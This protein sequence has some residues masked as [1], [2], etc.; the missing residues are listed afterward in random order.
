MQKIKLILPFIL[1]VLVK[2]VLLAQTIDP[3]F[4]LSKEYQVIDGFGAAVPDWLY[5]YNLES[6]V[7]DKAINDLGMSILR[8]YPH[9]GF[10]P[11][12]E[13][14]SPFNAELEKFNLS[15]SGL[16]DQIKVINNFAS[17]GLQKLILSVFSPPAWMK[18]N[19]SVDNGGELRDDMYN[20]FAEFYSA[21]VQH[22]NAQSLVDVYAISPENE[23]R[24]GQWYA[25]CVYN[26]EQM[27]DIIKVLGARFE[28][29]GLKVQIFAAEDLLTWF[30]EYA[31][32]MMA[33]SIC[34]KYT[35]IV[36]THA[37]SDGISP[38]SI[39]GAKGIWMNASSLTEANN[40]SLWMTE[41]SGYSE[42]WHAKDGP[43]VYA[44]LMHTA[45][46]YG[47]VSGWVWLTLNTGTGANEQE[48]LMVNKVPK[49]IY[50]VSKNF[51]RFIRPGAVQ[52]HCVDNEDE[53]VLVTAYK[54]G[55]ES[56]LT[57]VAINTGDSPKMLSLAME[58]KPKE[59][60][61]YKTTAT[62][63][64]IMAGI[65][66]ATEVELSPYSVNTFVAEGNNHLPTIN[67]VDTKYWLMGQN[68]KYE[69]NLSGISDG[70]SFSQN[71]SMEVVSSN[72]DLIPNPVLNYSDGSSDATLL[73][74]P[75]ENQSGI[76]TI[77]VRL[78][79]DGGQDNNGFFSKHEMSFDVYVLPYVNKKP[80]IDSIP[81]QNVILG[82]GEQVVTL[83]GI[84]DGNDGSQQITIRDTR[85]NNN[86]LKNVKI[87]Y[88]QGDST[89]KYI[90]TPR[91]K[92]SLT[93]SLTLTDG[94]DRY[95]GGEN[96][97]TVH[98]NINV[99][100]KT[101]VENLF[102]PRLLVYPNPATE[103][104]N[105]MK[106]SW[107]TDQAKVTICGISGEVILQHDVHTNEESFQLPTENLTNGMYFIRVNSGGKEQVD[108]IVIQR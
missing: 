21:Y 18:T 74:H 28:N 52:I 25:S 91:T 99:Q 43:L 36:A 46:K 47:K 42:D 90:Y 105:I 71:L 103:S 22:L 6:S 29:D 16:T 101:G 48:A 32:V 41:T 98:F 104:I 7:A 17:A 5:V 70:D 51:Y 63:N 23:P 81:D 57:V 88:N 60:A 27:R 12:N 78:Q 2:T 75:N 54:H 86:V 95:L 106:Q 45:L 93:V 89:A 44:Q 33:D 82:S 96:E 3:E 55:E 79:D 87:E 8:V 84:N 38:S 85:S 58:N 35:D 9:N 10:E 31:E 26:P 92:G 34:R 97:T 50:Y 68:D 13:N 30:S 76:A 53:Q 72:P 64:C 102:V 73:V 83:T 61:H 49:K 40:K 39:S 77:T 15:H 65:Q 24:W 69:I 62:D 80:V 107:M 67:P 108:K 66:Y 19:N 56:R 14:N 37:Y 11:T 4:S 1:M 59:F 94:G 100:G 20:E